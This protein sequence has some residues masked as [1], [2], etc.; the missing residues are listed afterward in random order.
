MYYLAQEKLK[1][2]QVYG[3]NKFASSQFSIQGNASVTE[4]TST[5]TS[6]L[7]SYTNPVQLFPHKKDMKVDYGMALFYLPTLEKSHQWGMPYYANLATTTPMTLS[8]YQPCTC[9]AG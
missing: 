7:P 2:E 4:P 9:D 6:T 3:P 8:H 5:N 1:Q